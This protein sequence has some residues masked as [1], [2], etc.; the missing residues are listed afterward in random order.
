MH[1]LGGPAQNDTL[2]RIAML[3]YA[4]IVG[5]VIL[6]VPPY[7]PIAEVGNGLFDQLKAFFQNAAFR[8]TVPV[9]T[10][11]SGYLLFWS[12]LDQH[13]RKLAA[14]K[15]RTI[16]LPFLVFNLGLLVAAYWMQRWFG[17]AASYQLTPF[18]MP[19][20]INAALGL[21]KSPINYP[22]NFLRDL[23]AVMML[24]PLMGVLLRKLPW[25]G[26]VLVIIFFYNN[27]DGLFVLRDVM[28]IMFY[29]GGL[30]AVRGW[31]LQ[32]L[33]R[34]AWPCLLI[35][36]LACMAIVHFQV[37][38]TNYFRFIAP[39]LIWPAMALLS[40]TAIG[41]WLISQS[42]YSFFIFVAH[43]PLLLILA[44]VYKKLGGS[45]PYVIFWI[46]APLV[47]VMVLT[48]TYR[49]LMSS[50]PTAFSTIIG[51][52]AGARQSKLLPCATDEIGGIPER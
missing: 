12:G 16:V 52:R 50:F 34:F 29:I 26:L 5:I 42:P 41:R 36:I 2:Q 23:I 13:W 49:I 45:V 3:R 47:I 30:A 10:V 31:N 6:H 4:M 9:L 22:L 44:M 46:C 17:I 39:F 35:F 48:V 25:L 20:W 33:D 24:A 14:K 38:N 19:T 27:L 37:A 40:N 51:A 18:D 7:V 11:I 21:T 1:T 43:A 15:L 8:A 28:P 32:A